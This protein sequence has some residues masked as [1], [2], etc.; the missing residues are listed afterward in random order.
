ME[1]WTLSMLCTSPLHILC[2][3]FLSSW[4]TCTLD[5][6]SLVLWRGNI[7]YPAVLRGRWN[8]HAI[9]RS[10]PRSGHCKIKII[11][12]KQLLHI[13]LSLVGILKARLIRLDV[14]TPAA[15]L[16]VLPAAGWEALAWWFFLQIVK[17][18]GFLPYYAKSG[19][20]CDQI[21]VYDCCGW[22]FWNRQESW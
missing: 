17:T 10:L 19:L 1:Q 8:A 2:S 18:T 14:V 4:H 7:Y 12:L 9:F 11:V 22:G 6:R 20:A 15:C 3:R 16:L 5:L 13:A 21:N